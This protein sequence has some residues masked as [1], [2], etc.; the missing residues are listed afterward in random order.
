MPS[1]RRKTIA[2]VFA[3]VEVDENGC[4]LWQGARRS[5]YG[6]MRVN[7]QNADLHRLSWEIHYGSI[8]DGL[9]VCHA[10]DVRHCMNPMHLF[11]GT[12][13]DNQRDAV[14]KGVKIGKVLRG[15][16]NGFSHIPDTTVAAVRE[17]RAAGETVESIART[18]DVSHG[19]VSMVTRNK[20]RAAA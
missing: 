20:M 8:P 11:L 6:V 1:S 15:E 18:F 4:W 3:R 2:D 10:C 9:L 19:W 17:C 5:G 12:V 16:A 14:S 13:S 7:G